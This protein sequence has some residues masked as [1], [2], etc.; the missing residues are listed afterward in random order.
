[1]LLK[2][3]DVCGVGVGVPRWSP[4]QGPFGHRLSSPRQGSA[5]YCSFRC[6]IIGTAKPTFRAAVFLGAV[7][8]GFI[9]AGSFTQFL[10]VLLI[11]FGILAGITSI[12]MSLLSALG[13]YFKRILGY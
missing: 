4:K 11:I 1:M 13:F 10:P 3:C 6:N 9:I 2:R 8:I 5:V 7:A 12:V